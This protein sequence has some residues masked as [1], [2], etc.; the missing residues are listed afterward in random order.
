MKKLELEIA[1]LKE[2]DSKLRVLHADELKYITDMNSHE[3][4]LYE[5]K[6]KQLQGTN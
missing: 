5:S 6:I 2:R 1:S 3:I 4:N